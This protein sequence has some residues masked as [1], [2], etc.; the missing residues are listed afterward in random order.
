M[1]RYDEALDAYSRIQREIKLV[2][3]WSKMAQALKDR[4]PTTSMNSTPVRAANAGWMGAWINGATQEDAMWLLRLGIPC[5]VLHEVET[6][7]RTAGIRDA[8]VLP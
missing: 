4:P 7:P 2:S 5:Y 3:A 8:S 6:L 1:A